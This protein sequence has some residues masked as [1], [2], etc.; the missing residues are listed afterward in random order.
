M[1]KGSEY[2][3]LQE[4]YTNGQQAYEKVFNIVSHRGNANQNHKRDPS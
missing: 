4:R 3:V 1:G 2:I